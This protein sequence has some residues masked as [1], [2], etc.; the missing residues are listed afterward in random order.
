MEC[1]IEPSINKN[2]HKQAPAVIPHIL[3]S[4]SPV[5]ESRISEITHNNCQSAK[6]EERNQ[7]PEF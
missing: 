4:K 7:A 6:C 1:L 3:H 2:N 5:N